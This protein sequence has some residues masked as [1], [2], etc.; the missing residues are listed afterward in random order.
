M[1]LLETPRL[2]IRRLVRGDLPW[3]AR[4]HADPEVM[5]YVRAPDTAEQ[6]AA[7]LEAL[8]EEQAAHPGLG[9]KPAEL[10]DGGAVIGWFVLTHLDGGPEVELGYRLFPEHWGRGL[11]TEGA[12]ALAEHAFEEVGLSRLVAVARPD[13]LAS[14]RVLE[15]AGF[16][17]EGLRRAYGRD[18]AYFVHSASTR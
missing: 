6:S 9:V 18:L 8:L 12:R 7:K 4:L 2:R 16:R 1:S 10:R 14:V 11:A 3:L 17:Q 13:N 5:R 15:K